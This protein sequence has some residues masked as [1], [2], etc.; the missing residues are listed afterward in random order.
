MPVSQD[1][2]AAGI[3]KWTG[4]ICGESWAWSGRPDS[5]RRHPAWKAGTLPLSYSRSRIN[6]PLNVNL[7]LVEIPSPYRPN[8]N[9]ISFQLPKERP[10]PLQK[11]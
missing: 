8:C 11:P 4:R 7:K 10:V 2:M 3:L 9:Q 1:Q 6:Y 5:N